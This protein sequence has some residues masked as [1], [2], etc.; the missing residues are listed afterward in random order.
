MPRR[1]KS[2]S[3]YVLG[4][5]M[6]IAV[7]FGFVILMFVPVLNGS[8]LQRLLISCLSM[9][10][11]AAHFLYFGEILPPSDHDEGRSRSSAIA[12]YWF[13]SAFFMMGTALATEDKWMILV[14]VAV[15]L[16]VVFRLWSWKRRLISLLT[17]G[18]MPMP[19]IKL[20]LEEFGIEL[21][22]PPSADTGR[23]A[24]AALI[25]FIFVTD[26]KN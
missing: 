13:C 22:I 4:I 23:F 26:E 7:F 5:T 1:K 25:A 16:L 17:A 12:T 3:I 11:P 21:E 14:A 24:I 6:L 20:V 18:L 15:L 10:P 19:A 9:A 2:R 8:P